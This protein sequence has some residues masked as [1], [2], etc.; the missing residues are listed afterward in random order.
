MCLVQEA[1]WPGVSQG[2]A[3]EWETCF[4]YF[5]AN[6]SIASLRLCSGR[7]TTSGCSCVGHGRVPCVVFPLKLHR[8]ML[9]NVWL[10]VSTTARLNRM[11]EP[12]ILTIMRRC[13]ACF[14]VQ[15]FLSLCVHLYAVSQTRLLSRTFPCTLVDS[16]CAV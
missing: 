16:R 4:S 3:C 14:L 9:L 10:F 15:G 6:F 2:R 1:L 5:K 8:F 7:A 13:E 12:V 11:H